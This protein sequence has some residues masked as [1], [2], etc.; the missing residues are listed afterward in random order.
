MFAYILFYYIS[1]LIFRNRRLV[2]Q[3][4]NLR[5]AC[6][7]CLESKKYIK[8]SDKDKSKVCFHYDITLRYDVTDYLSESFPALS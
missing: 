1:N 5:K 3:V 4:S 6:F 7:V 2:L 8:F